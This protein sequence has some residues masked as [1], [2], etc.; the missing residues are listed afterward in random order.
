MDFIGQKRLKRGLRFKFVLML[1]LL[2]ILIGSILGVIL[3][4]TIQRHF[5]DQF[6]KRGLVI[7]ENIAA[8]SIFSIATED[9]T[10][11]LPML[12]KISRAEG[13]E[14][15]IVLNND[16]KVIAH[17]EVAQ[18]GK[19]LSDPLTGQ[20]LRTGEA[21]V[22]P[23]SHDGGEYYDVIA[24][25]EVSTEKGEPPTTKRV[26]VI[27]L[28][29]SLKTLQKDLVKFSLI[30]LSVLTALMCGGILVSLIFVG[31]I[32]TP[33]ERM[34]EAATQI[35]EGDFSQ[36]LTASSQDEVGVLAHA[37]S[38]MSSGLKGM[39]KKIQDASLL[40]TKMSEQ[41]FANT[42]KVREGAMHQADAVVNTSS[43]IGEMNAS[44]KNISENI[45]GLSALAETTS[46]SVIQMSA[47]VGHV[48][49]N[50]VHLA[51]SV[52]E[53]A[54]S[55]AQVSRSINEV[56]DHVGSLSSNAQQT[57][58][59]INEMDA[60]IKEVEKH[61]R[62]SAFLTGKVS[63]D[64]AELGVGAIEKTIAGMER[65]KETVEKSSNVID[66]LDERAEHIGKILTVI[67]EVTRQ[68][69][70][71][72]LNAAI[73]AAQAGEQGKGFSVVADEIK[74]LA[75]RTGASTQEIAQLVRDVQSEAKDAVVSIREGSHSV[76]EGMRLSID[77]RT[78][79]SQIL[80]SSKRSCEMSRQIENAT[81]AQVRET[82]HVTQLM[83]K[84][85][86]MIL[87]ITTA[88]QTQKKGLE[89][90]TEA[91][92]RMKDIMQEV[93]VSTEEQAKGSM[94]I[95]EAVENVTSRFQQIAY[96][97]EEQKRGSD[98]I[99]KSIVEI[100]Q[101]TQVSAEMVQ[102]MNQ[103]VE[104]LVDQANVLKGEV[105]RFKI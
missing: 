56:V 84:M 3:L 102:Q 96:S 51:S 46:S 34:T 7:A 79:L 6:Q 5:E 70:L 9:N 36:L 33:L 86:L 31:I 29:I 103:V 22:F 60:S 44:V 77:A 21:T 69:N 52:E 54:S 11:L 81:V 48:A 53:M 47:S 38:Q 24:P 71:L 88:M 4:K 65:I 67:N 75:D 35:A 97:M 80:E 49:V 72:A 30:I 104:G 26:G 2:F 85:N 50:T 93:K 17:T 91:S 78:S 25:S 57:T 92:D 10:M 62:E 28:G 90:I 20:A 87:Q 83:E 74:N 94:Q 98:I 89:E 40:I 18:I 39:I 59:S 76:E 12:K 32:I 73:L 37:F 1:S 68:T 64:A 19:V 42:Q 23:Y 101:I 15:V 43:S 58:A 8:L 66:Q 61:A 27:R 82:H 14:Y 95:S 105:N 55:L 41:L 99:M 100:N 63:Q 45:D 13:I 16:G